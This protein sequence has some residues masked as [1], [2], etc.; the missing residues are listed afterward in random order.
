LYKDRALLPDGNQLGEEWKLYTQSIAA[1][2]A[3]IRELR[4][5]GRSA[6]LNAPRLDDSTEDVP[7]TN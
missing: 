2:S 5:A 7:I 6:I 4:V 1:E 3:V